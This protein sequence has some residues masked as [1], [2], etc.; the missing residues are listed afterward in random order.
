MEIEM[1]REFI[2][3][4]KHMNVTRAADELHLAPSSLS[5]HISAME[6]E[7]GI[8]LITHKATKLFLTTAGSQL[9]DAA[10]AIAARY[11]NLIHKVDG[12]KQAGFSD[13]RIVYALDDRSII[14]IVSLAYASLCDTLEGLSV[15]SEC[16]RGKSICEALDDD[17]VDIAI[18]YDLSGIDFDAYSAVPLIEDSI[19]IA[20]PKCAAVEGRTS[21]DPCE[22]MARSVPWPTASRDNYLERAMRM[23]DGCEKKPSIHWID[24]DN[25]DTF[26]MHMLDDQE[27][28]F[29]SKKQYEEY[30]NCV[31]TC[32]MNS[33]VAYEVERVD[34]RF[35]RY[36]VYRTDTPNR[37]AA[38]FAEAMANVDF[39]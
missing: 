25:M 13:V 36:A 2:T 33:V 37:A 11:D 27:M 1:L 21:I 8:P 9:L 24:A 39:D 31:P 16:I 30:R 22:V 17:E 34:S 23:F 15:R 26:F 14:D 6:K 38:L 20:L 5:R 29:F 18:L 3:F 7:L 19:L 28:W 32:F 12:L 35:T 10:C 4:S